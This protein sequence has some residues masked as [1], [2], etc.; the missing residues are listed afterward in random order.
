MLGIRL[1]CG[2]PAP[3]P[4][5]SGEGYLAGGFL[6]GLS[7]DSLLDLARA[8]SFTAGAVG[9]DHPRRVDAEEIVRIDAR[10]FRLH[11]SLGHERNEGR[12]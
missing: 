6:P 9:Y 4:L 10:P 1:C 7:Q 5:G 12:A 3:G 11:R 2:S 8:S